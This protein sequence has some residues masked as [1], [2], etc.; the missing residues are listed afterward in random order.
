[1]QHDAGREPEIILRV[2]EEP[3]LHEISLKPPAHRRDLFVI[4]SAT[5]GSGK[6]SIG[7]RDGIQALVPGS[8]QGMGE[9]SEL[10]HGN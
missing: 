2:A 6:R 5:Q 7:S 8:E 9:G 10:A 4:R 1:M 3:G